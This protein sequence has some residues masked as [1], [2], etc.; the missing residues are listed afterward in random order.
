MLLQV[1]FPD[2]VA[3]VDYVAS[4]SGHLGTRRAPPTRCLAFGLEAVSGQCVYTTL[5]AYPVT[6]RVRQ[7]GR[8]RSVRVRYLVGCDEEVCRHRRRTCECVRHHHAVVDRVVHRQFRQRR[9]RRCN[10]NP[11]QVSAGP[12]IRYIYVR[13]FPL[14]CALFAEFSPE[15]KWTDVLGCK[16]YC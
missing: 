7:C 13:S 14:L 15:S 6:V 8:V 9:V 12:C 4:R 16:R 5:R 3:S 10:Q 11:K 2:S 1:S